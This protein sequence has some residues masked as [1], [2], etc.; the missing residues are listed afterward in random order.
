M[1]M[2]LVPGTGGTPVH[3]HP[4][5]IEIY[6]VIEGRF[7]VFVDGAWRT[8]SAGEKITVP[9][10]TPH[11]FRNSSPHRV[12]V[13]NTHQPAM[14]FAE[15]FEKLHG[16]I[17]RDIVR[18]QKMTPRALIHLSMIMASHPDE[19]RPIRPPAFVVRMLA[20]LGRLLGYRA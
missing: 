14:R 5:A 2:D 10:D 17:K 12:R 13:M 11:T 8:L 15:Y 19:I 4:S 18:S 7:D 3:T 20:A 9:N 6:E 16:L 1:E